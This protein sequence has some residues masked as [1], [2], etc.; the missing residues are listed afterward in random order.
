M[1]MSL[2]LLNLS[3][4]F[5]K[6]CNEVSADLGCFCLFFLFLYFSFLC[7]LGCV[8]F[9]RGNTVTDSSGKENISQVKYSPCIL[10]PPLSFLFRWVFKLDTRSLL[11]LKY[12]RENIYSFNCITNETSRKILKTWEDVFQMLKT[13]NHAYMEYSISISVT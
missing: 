12:P 6:L 9:V 3:L 10:S 5:L 7:W 4:I 1:Y 13:S 2:S 11:C 8:A